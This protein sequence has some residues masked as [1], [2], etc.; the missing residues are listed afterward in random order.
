MQ[1]TVNPFTHRLDAFEQSTN[2]GGQVE[3]LTG[4]AGG[5]V[6]PNAAKNIFVVGG[7]GIYVTGNPATNTLTIAQSA[8]IEGTGQT[9]GAV[10]A[11]I[12]TFDLESTPGVY[13]FKIEI[14]GFSTSSLG[15]GYDVT[16]CFRTDGTTSVEIRTQSSDE[17]EEG[18]LSGCDFDIVPSAG[19]LVVR[20]TGTAGQT[21]NWLAVLTYTFK[22]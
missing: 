19:N 10:T 20:V 3:T 7:T 5:A 13:L 2:P 6:G 15:V 16:A 21:I 18:A 9:I 12:L 11:D 14:V 22:G 4:N 1:F 8:A 17:F